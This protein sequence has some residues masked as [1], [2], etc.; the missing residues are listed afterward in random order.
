MRDHLSCISSLFT[1][2]DCGQNCHFLCDLFNGCILRQLPQRLDK[3]LFVRHRHWS[4]VRLGLIA[5]YHFTTLLAIACAITMLARNA[6]SGS[7][8]ESWRPISSGVVRGV[9]VM[10]SGAASA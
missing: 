10:V 3:H 5:Q 7:R 4:P 1:A 9:S 2:A 8:S 6:A